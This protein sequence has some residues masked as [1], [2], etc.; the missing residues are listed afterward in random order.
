MFIKPTEYNGESI[1]KASQLV[2]TA[3]DILKVI[4]DVTGDAALITDLDVVIQDLEG[5]F[6]SMEIM[7]L[8]PVYGGKKKPSSEDAAQ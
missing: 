3:S 1:I 6:A 2:K 5:I 8:P 7:E 4:R